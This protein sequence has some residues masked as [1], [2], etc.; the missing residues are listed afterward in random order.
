MDKIRQKLKD[1]HYPENI[2]KLVEAELLSIETE[3]SH[4]LSRK[5]HYVTL[6]TD[7]PFG[8][9]APEIFDINSARKLLEEEHYGMEKLKKRILEF[10]AVSKLKG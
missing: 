7:Y 1:R 6:L 4:D 5:K 2:A 10:I 8:V 3:G 9:L